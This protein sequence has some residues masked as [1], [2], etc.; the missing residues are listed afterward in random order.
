MTNPDL[1]DDPIAFADFMTPGETVLLHFEGTNFGTIK[2]VD[3]K[4]WDK[5]TGDEHYTKSLRRGREWRLV[6]GGDVLRIDF[7]VPTHFGKSGG[8]GSDEL[9]VTVTNEESGPGNPGTYP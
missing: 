9:E 1:E 2:S 4:A 5:I 3:I 6:R 8:S 7:D